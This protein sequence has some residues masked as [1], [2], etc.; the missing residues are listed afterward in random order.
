[1]FVPERMVLH[2]LRNSLQKLSSNVV[3]KSC[4]HFELHISD[5][6]FAIAPSDTPV[7]LR[8]SL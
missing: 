2:R 8:S 6:Y 1:M 5:D 3:S 4:L 7:S